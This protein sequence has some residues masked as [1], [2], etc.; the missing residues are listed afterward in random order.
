MGA[1]E[2]FAQ[3]IEWY[4][5]MQSQTP[6]GSQPVGPTQATPAPQQGSFLKRLL[7]DPQFMEAALGLGA[8]LAGGRL[9]G[10]AA[11]GVQQSFDR[12]RERKKEEVQLE[13]LRKAD[14]RD[15]RQL[16]LD[17][18]LMKL[19]REG[20]GVEKIRAYLDLKR[21]SEADEKSQAAETRLNRK[22]AHDL[23]VDYADNI[24]NITADQFPE[25]IRKYLSKDELDL[26]AKGGAYSHEQRTLE[27][28]DRKL[29][30]QE[31]LRERV[32]N[33]LVNDPKANFQDIFNPQVLGLIGT[34]WLTGI[35]QE[36]ANLAELDEAERRIKLGQA[37]NAFNKFYSTAQG[38][39]I[40]EVSPSGDVTPKTAIPPQLPVAGEDIVDSAVNGLATGL[41]K[42]LSEVAPEIRMQVVDRFIQTGAQ[43]PLQR[44]DRNTLAALETSAQTMRQI[45]NLADNIYYADGPLAYLVGAVSSI[46]EKLKLND[47]LTL[48]KTK[49]QSLVTLARSIGG[50]VGVI[51]NTDM[52]RIQATMPFLTDPSTTRKVKDDSIREIKDLIQFKI[53][54][55]IKNL[56]P[57]MR[58]PA[59][60]N[61][62]RVYKS[63]GTL[64]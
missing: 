5:K 47:D 62:R 3:L 43:L 61:T 58:P 39:G 56:P 28:L 46:R 4:Q 31:K 52:E 50:E 64:E 34:E 23:A 16:Q 15:E 54:T 63:D 29:A 41:V 27:A 22:Q 48:L 11:Q 19:R 60:S 12:Q 9:G 36:A 14:E 53:D 49:I 1:E 10:Y 35:R 20:A 24:P 33:T 45:E 55:F 17:E 51:N 26:I 6:L 25:E 2:E 37:A 13:R 32:L 57:A 44:E 21:S 42:G 18:E 8:G 7:G 30:V 38:L 40:A 59:R